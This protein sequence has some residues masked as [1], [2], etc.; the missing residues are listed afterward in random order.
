MMNLFQPSVKLARK[1][2]H[3]ARLT[4]V[5]DQ[6]QTP[7]D[8]LVASDGG[9]RAMI[10]ALGQL[11]TRL[12]PFALAEAIDRKLTRIHRLATHRQSPR[13]AAADATGSHINPPTPPSPR[14]RLHMRSWSHHRPA[15]V[16]S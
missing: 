16:T 5:Y 3:G 6:A 8:R 13:P 14:P 1:V 4:R 2:R 15:T 11:R 12:D 7:L 10:T 9:D